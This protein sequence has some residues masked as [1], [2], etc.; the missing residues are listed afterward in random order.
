[1]IARNRQCRLL[2]RHRLPG[3]TPRSSLRFGMRAFRNSRTS[4][5]FYRVAPISSTSLLPAPVLN[6]GPFPPPALPGLLST[7]GLSATPSRPVYPSPASGWSSR[8]TT[9]WGF[10]C[11][12][13]FPCV[14]AVVTTP[15]QRLGAY[16]ALFPSRIS[17]PRYGRR[18]GLRND[19]FEACSTFTRVTACTLALS[20]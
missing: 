8:P 18:V 5:E 7:T 17:L 11:C 15:A 12:A 3:P 2:R 20:P 1:V 19:L 10:P 6:Q 16:F 9:R 13:R 14:H 4:S